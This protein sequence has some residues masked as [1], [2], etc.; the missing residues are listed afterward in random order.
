[1]TGMGRI[2]DMILALA[3]AVAKSNRAAGKS[4]WWG[5]ET[6]K[7]SAGRNRYGRVAVAHVQGFA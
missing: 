4:Q 7:L 3:G 5:V 2:S 1:M 6:P